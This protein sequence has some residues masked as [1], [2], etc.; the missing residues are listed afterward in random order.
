LWGSDRLLREVGAE[1]CNAVGE[2]GLYLSAEVVG[3]DLV[4]V[5]SHAAEGE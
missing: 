4:F 3:D 5:C 2:V 1:G